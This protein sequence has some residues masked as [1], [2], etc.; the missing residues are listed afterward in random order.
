MALKKGEYKDNKTRNFHISWN[1]YPNSLT[2]EELKNRL[3]NL[4]NVEYLILG[5]EKGSKEQTPHIQGYVR[6]TNSIKL[7]S[8]EKLL[9]NNNNTYGYV[10]IAYGNDNN[11]Q[12]YCSKQNE[13]IEYGT[14]RNDGEIKKDMSIENLIDDIISGLDYIELCKKYHKYV[15]YH[16]NAFKELYTDILQKYNAN[17]IKQIYINIKDEELPF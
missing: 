8:I 13:Y 4:A 16:Y 17:K 10:E 6:Y 12:E 5:K 15:L 11:N 3:I 7:G 14:P 9:K 1:N 2:L